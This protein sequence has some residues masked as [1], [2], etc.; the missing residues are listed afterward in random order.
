MSGFVCPPQ[1]Y[2]VILLMDNDSGS[3]GIE[4]L[5]NRDFSDTREIHDGYTYVCENLY[6]VKT[7]L[8]DGK[9]ETKIED[10]FDCKTLSKKLGDKTFSASN[11]FDKSLYFGKRKFA[12]LIVKQNHKEIDFSNFKMIIDLFYL[13]ICDYQ[14]R[15]R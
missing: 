11:N 13:V 15:L 5:I 9:K 12:E 6:V 4:G 2:P 3:N 8:I 1:N 7:P 14:K 10:F